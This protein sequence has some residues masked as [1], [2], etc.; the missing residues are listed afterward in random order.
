LEEVAATR[1]EGLQA[2]EERI[3]LDLPLAARLGL[4]LVVFLFEVNTIAV[5]TF[6]LLHCRVSLL[7]QH[8]QDVF[9]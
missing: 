5:D 6:Q 1:N 2:S 8:V 9:A 4:L 3:V 7:F